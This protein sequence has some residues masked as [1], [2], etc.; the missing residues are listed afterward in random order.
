MNLQEINDQAQ[1]IMNKERSGEEMS[2][3]QF[4]VALRNSVSEWYNDEYEKLRTAQ[5]TNPDLA[6]MNVQIGSTL[7]RYITEVTLP[8]ILT[9][10]KIYLPGD[11]VSPTNMECK[12][13]SILK[14]IKVI[15]NEL[16]SRR[17]SNPLVRSVNIYA[18]AT[19]YGD[20]IKMNPTTATDF[21][22]S[23]LREPKRSNYKYTAT[24]GDNS[25]HVYQEETLSFVTYTFT[26]VGTA[27]D[28]VVISV[29]DGTNDF[30][31]C[32]YDT[33]AG[34]TVNT[35]AYTVSAIINKGINEHGYTATINPLTPTMV[36]IACPIGTGADTGAYV[37]TVTPDAPLA[38]TLSGAN[39]TG[40]VAGSVQLDVD[41][42]YH[43]E[44]LRRLLGYFSIHLKEFE[45]TKYAEELKKTP[46]L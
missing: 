9:S 27:G 38:G 29:N 39:P 41:N 40:G 31:L 25:T 22:L 16:F 14:H 33:V 30:P 44:I 1:F 10:G 20:Y 32:S 36:T 17:R 46:S 19:I 45:I 2:P 7:R 12:V 6:F 34:E 8:T 24:T 35:L 3:E 37:F 23:Y 28:G 18:I 13:D 4:T 26:N 15:P 5:I 43:K 42:I 21:T 11:Y